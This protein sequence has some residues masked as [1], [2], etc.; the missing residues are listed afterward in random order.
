MQLKWL[1]MPIPVVK[2][3][4]ILILVILFKHLSRVPGTTY[5]KL[6]STDK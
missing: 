6:S 1:V 2:Y 4:W 3:G 5:Y